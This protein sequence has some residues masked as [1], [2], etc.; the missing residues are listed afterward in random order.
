MW[1][2]VAY[3]WNAESLLHKYRY[4]ATLR[5]KISVIS[6]SC[7]AISVTPFSTQGKC[8]TRDSWDLFRVCAKHPWW[9]NIIFLEK[10]WAV[11]NQWKIIEVH[12]YHW[13]RMYHD[14]CAQ[15][16]KFGN[17]WM[18][19]L[20]WQ[21]VWVSYS[22][23]V[24]MLCYIW[25]KIFATLWY[26]SRVMYTQGYTHEKMFNTFS[27]V[28]LYLVIAP[29]FKCGDNTSQSQYGTVGLNVNYLMGGLDSKLSSVYFQTPCSF[30]SFLYNF[31][32]K[33]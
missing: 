6:A 1:C 23:I 26:T 27:L 30:S 21:Y 19:L 11:Q 9:I 20:T 10:E 12:L 8:T 28:I 15:Q 18:V 13:W 4:Q 17:S 29:C 2:S 33:F 5:V 7:N 32:G 31:P 14:L 22:K 16:S 3:G 25:E 24:P